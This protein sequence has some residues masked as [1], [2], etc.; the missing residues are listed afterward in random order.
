M[1]SIKTIGKKPIPIT[2]STLGKINANSGA[3]IDFMNPTPDMFLIE[4]IAIGLANICRF[5]GQI[6]QFYS[7]AN[8]SLLVCALAPFSH[9]K[10]ALLHDATEAYLGDVVKPLKNILGSS[11]MDIEKRFQECINIKFGLDPEKLSN[12]KAADTRALV[13]EEDALRNGNWGPLRTCI[14]SDSIVIKHIRENGPAIM[15]FMSVYS[16]LFKS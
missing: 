2:D 3:E 7:V 8:H 16:K 15:A 11:Y 13:L 4:D 10:E 1:S 5:G 12:I 9:K 14:E 6:P